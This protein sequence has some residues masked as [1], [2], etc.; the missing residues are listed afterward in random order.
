MKYA[1]G[2]LLSSFGLFWVVEGLGYFG[3]SGESPE[4][5]GGSWALLAI[6]L[7]W[8]VIS[9][10]TVVVLQRLAPSSETSP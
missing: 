2:L 9:R 3:A 6:L 4:W 5:P 1:V 7:A 10:A 8:L